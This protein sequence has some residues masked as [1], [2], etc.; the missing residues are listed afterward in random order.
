MYVHNRFVSLLCSDSSRGIPTNIIVQ[1]G[2]PGKF[3]RTVDS[4]FGQGFGTEGFSLTSLK[5]KPPPIFLSGRS[6]SRPSSRK[7]INDPH[8][9][10]VSVELRHGA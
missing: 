10:V 1:L 2:P 3:R 7:L 8:R 9:I 4:A 5:K 6:Y